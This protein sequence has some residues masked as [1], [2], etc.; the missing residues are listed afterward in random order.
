M[1]SINSN[2]DWVDTPNPAERGFSITAKE[3][4]NDELP[5]FN[6]RTFYWRDCPQWIK[7]AEAVPESL[8]GYTLVHALKA[9][10]Q[11]RTFI[12]GRTRSETE[13]NT[14]FQISWVKRTYHW[15]T[16]LLKLWFEKGNLPLTAQ[17]DIM[18]VA[19][20]ARTHPR[21]KIRDGA[22]YPT[23][24]KISRFLSEVPWPKRENRSPTPITD[25][26]NWS[27][28]GS[29]GSIPECLHPGCR[30]PRYQ[31]SGQVIFGAGTPES[32]V[33]GD[34]V[35]QEFPATPM[36]DWERHPVEDST[37]NLNGFWFREL[38]EAFPPIDDRESTS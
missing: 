7:R 17:T 25:S 15:P 10:Y 1:P 23:W 18:S 29:S 38:V 3:G 6:T 34:L 24:F 13:R 21:M 28:D 9:D 36:T 32:E 16:V 22:E 5:D 27:F 19:T 2:F 35:A 20:A 12:F 8:Q 4:P 37:Q 26:P 30:F 11:K 33:S 14:P 31:T